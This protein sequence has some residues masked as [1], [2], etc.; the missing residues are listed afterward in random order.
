MKLFDAIAS[1]GDEG[2]SVDE[3]A[4]KTTADPLLVCKELQLLSDIDA[5][6]TFTVRLSRNLAAAGVLKETGKEKFAPTPLSKS[7]VSSSPIS[8][9]IIH[10][11]VHA[12]SMQLWPY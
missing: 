5:D 9:C 1:V 8:Q 3:I 12:L 4:S 6:G 2:I 7:Y 11:Y 10:M